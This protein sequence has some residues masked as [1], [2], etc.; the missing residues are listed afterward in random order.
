MMYGL[1]LACPLVPS[2]KNSPPRN[3]STSESTDANKKIF[4]D[5]LLAP[6]SNPNAS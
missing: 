5:F 6:A 4:F 1:A 2:K 3:R